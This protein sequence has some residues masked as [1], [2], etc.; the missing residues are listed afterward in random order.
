MS[1]L[2]P[3]IILPHHALGDEATDA[4]SETGEVGRIAQELGHEDELGRYVCKIQNFGQQVPH[5]QIVAR[6]A[7]ETQTQFGE[8]PFAFFAAQGLKFQI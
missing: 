5:T 2:S 1:P 7:V 8:E 6:A 4:E 3:A